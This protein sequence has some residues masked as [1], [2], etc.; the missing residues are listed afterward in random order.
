M[1]QPKSYL[2][3]NTFT[4]IFNDSDGIESI[5]IAVALD[6]DYV[7]LAYPRLLGTF[8]VVNGTWSVS[9][10]IDFLLLEKLDGDYV[11]EVET[12]RINRNQFKNKESMMQR[13]EQIYATYYDKVQKFN[14]TD[15]ERDVIAQVKGLFSG[16]ISL[17]K[18][19]DT[20]MVID[21]G[22]H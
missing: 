13:L 20:N 1:P 6:N 10:I 4:T 19:L 17:L 18:V 12:T 3:P 14:T 15:G 5:E 9:F 21:L 8:K 7:N 16:A 11:F 22:K 2:P